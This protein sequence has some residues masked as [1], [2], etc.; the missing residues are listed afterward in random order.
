MLGHTLASVVAQK[1]ETSKVQPND[2]VRALLIPRWTFLG[3]CET[4]R[5]VWHLLTVQRHIVVGA[6][7]VDAV[8]NGD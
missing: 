8:L 4:C 6:P 5:K 7:C 2:L 3:R 1:L